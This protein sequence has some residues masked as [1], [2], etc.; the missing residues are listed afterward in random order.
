MKD[1]LLALFYPLTEEE[2]AIESGKA[3]YGW[4]ADGLTLKKDSFLSEGK[5]ISVR[6]NTR[7]IAAPAHSHDF[8]EMAYVLNGSLTHVV[9]GKTITLAAGDLLIMNRAATHSVLPC[10]RDDIMINFIIHPAFFD[11][12]YDMSGMDD[13]PMRRFFLDC[14][15]GTDDK[16]DYL[17]FN[18]GNIRPV[19]NLL[20]NLILSLK[21][22]TPY[23][24]ST[25]QMTM[26]LLLRL[27]QF[28][29]ESVRSD[30][31]NTDIIWHVQQYI[32]S[33][34][35]NGNLK[36]AASLLHYDY[37]WL[38]RMV[39]RKTG[40]TFTDLIQ[41]RRIQQAM[42]L[43]RNTNYPVTEISRQVGYANSTY[44]YKLFTEVYG[45]TPKEVR[46]EGVV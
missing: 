33:N 21:N 1:G 45:K 31:E 10:G 42:Y 13:S 11:R 25:N 30:L 41:E 38:S 34:Y 4:I 23:K 29:A 15:L 39:I 18:V 46:K 16:P 14:I 35:R 36:D 27:L 22:G 3:P 5:L 6:A 2:K 9:E 26:A 32:E 7:F 40:K 19:T 24:Q 8:I 37:R 20:E 43:V 12:V 17:L 44:F 28:H